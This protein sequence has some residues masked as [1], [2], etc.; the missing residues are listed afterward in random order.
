MS[1]YILAASLILRRTSFI[2]LPVFLT[3]VFIS[4]LLTQFTELA[5][6]SEILSLSSFVTLL[7]FSARAFNWC[8]VSS[9]IV[10]ES[11][12]NLVYQAGVDLFLASLLA[13]VATFFA[14]L[15]INP[16]R[17]PSSFQ[18]GLF[19]FHWGFLFLSLL[20]FLVSMLSLLHVASH[21]LAADQKSK[22]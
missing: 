14:W 17:I 22:R 1:P 12:L 16:A 8:R 2:L 3:V 21:S 6:R 7:S 5:T 11:L 10:S 9:S 15:Q 13:L 20:L 18:T 4:L 19:L